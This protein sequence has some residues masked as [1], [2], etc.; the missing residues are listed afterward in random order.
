MFLIGIKLDWPQIGLCI[1]QRVVVSLV[2][3]VAALLAGNEGKKKNMETTVLSLGFRRNGKGHGNYHNGFKVQCLEG[4]E[5]KMEST[6]MGY[7]GTSIRI[8]SSLNPKP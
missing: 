8:L 3:K 5:K 1:H 2:F 7:I 6:T 4:V